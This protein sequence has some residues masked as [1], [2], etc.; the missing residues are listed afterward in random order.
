MV[1]SASEVENEPSMIAFCSNFTSFSGGMMGASVV[2]YGL[3][4]L[5][6]SAK[7]AIAVARMTDDSE[8][9]YDLSSARVA[10]LV[11]RITDDSAVECEFSEFE[12]FRGLADSVDMMMEDSDKE[13]E[14]SDTEVGT[15]VTDAS[16]TVHGP[17]VT[18]WRFLIGLPPLRLLGLFPFLLLCLLPC[19]LLLGAIV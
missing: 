8:V 15:S 4:S 14:D 12:L 11:A 10:L 18:G 7:V 13:V 9:E 19:F 1:V 17:P 6:F 5:I 3:S 16:T 2:E